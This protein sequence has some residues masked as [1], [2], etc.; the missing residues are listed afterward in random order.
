VPFKLAGKRRQQL[1]VIAAG[2]EIEKG[3]PLPRDMQL[4]ARA[5]LEALRSSSPEQETS[6]ALKKSRTLKKRLIKAVRKVKATKTPAEDEPKEAIQPI[7]FLN[8]PK[9]K[10]PVWDK[11]ALAKR[12]TKKDLIQLRL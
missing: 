3:S 6:E 2:E 10:L 8:P 1:C 5:A 11:H 9:P 7:N 4:S 12:L